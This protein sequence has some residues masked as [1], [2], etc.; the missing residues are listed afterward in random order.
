MLLSVVAPQ[1]EV[2]M[3]GCSRLMLPMVPSLL[4]PPL[5]GGGLWLNA[6]Q[7]GAT[8]AEGVAGTAVLGSGEGSSEPLEWALG[9]SA[10]QDTFGSSTSLGVPGSSGSS[11][12]LSNTTGSRFV[13]RLQ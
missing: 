11:L 9:V 1:E 10:F 13:S 3:Q 7:G 2:E 5:L 6:R 12:S 8:M 4:L